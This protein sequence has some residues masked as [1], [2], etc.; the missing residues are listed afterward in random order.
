MIRRPPRSTL[1]PYTTLSR[2]SGRDAL[3][4]FVIAYEAAA[5][6]TKVID[7]KRAEQRGPTYRG[8]WHV[9]L[10]APVAAALACCRLKGATV[11]QTARAIGIATASSAG[12]RRR[13]G[14]MT[15]ALHSGNGGRGG[16]EAAL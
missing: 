14:T 2:S 11:E 15:K 8:W 13:L 10:I 7:A 5:R 4:A 9:G 16:M 3:A 1:F 12:L 6:L